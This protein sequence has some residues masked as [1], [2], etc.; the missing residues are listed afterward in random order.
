[1]PNCT[2]VRVK[3]GKRYEYRVSRV[4][5]YIKEATFQVLQAEAAAKGVRVGRLAAMWLD[6]LAQ[7]K[8]PA[9]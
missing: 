1:M 6:E 7:N 9:A 8:T 3:N 2:S 5:P 4:Q